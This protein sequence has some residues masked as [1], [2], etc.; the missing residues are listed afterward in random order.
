MS[1]WAHA[2]RAFPVMLEVLEQKAGFG[3]LIYEYCVPRSM[4]GGKAELLP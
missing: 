3:G 1:A 4:A 2:V